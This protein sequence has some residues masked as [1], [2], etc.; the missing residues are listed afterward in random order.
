MF[1]W[2]GCS[3]VDYGIVHRDFW[4]KIFKVK[5]LVGHISNHCSISFGFTCS[6]KFTYFKKDIYP[7]KPNFR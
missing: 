7:L 2:N 1:K 3:T 4:N 5:D 6:Y